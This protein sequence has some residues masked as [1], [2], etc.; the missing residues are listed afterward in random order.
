M[1]RTLTLQEGE[2]SSGGEEAAHASLPVYSQE[3]LLAVMPVLTCN[4]APA[5]F[6]AAAQVGDTGFASAV[7]HVLQQSLPLQQASLW[8]K[9]AVVTGAS[10][11]V[12]PV[13]LA[14]TARVVW[15]LPVLTLLCIQP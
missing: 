12:A 1:T 14:S 8:L 6:Q 2:G 5:A 13:V 3:G 4:H 9:P 11:S 10:A 7:A 15:E